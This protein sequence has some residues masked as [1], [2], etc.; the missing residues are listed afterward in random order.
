MSPS[1]AVSNRL[2]K[3]LPGPVVEVR[4]RFAPNSKSIGLVVLTD[5]LLLVPLFPVLV[6][7]TSTGVV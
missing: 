5:P 1:D 7:V 6:A 3:P 4:T 2:V